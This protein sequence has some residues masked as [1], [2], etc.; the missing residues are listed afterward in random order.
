M[1]WLFMTWLLASGG[2]VAGCNESAK[3][4]G[5]R[6]IHVDDL[7]AMLSAGPGKVYVFDANHDEFRHK[8]GVIAQATLLSSAHDYDVKKVLPADK[9]AP[10]VFYCSNKL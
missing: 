4:E 1:R 7:A 9:G 8:E 3:E 6:I 5:F 10:L 2:S